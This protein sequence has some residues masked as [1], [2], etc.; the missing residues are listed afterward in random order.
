MVTVYIL[1]SKKADRYY[2]GQTSELENRLRRHN[3]GGSSYTKSGTPWKLVYREKFETRSEAMK[4]EK[5]LKN[6]KNLEYIKRVIHSSRN[7][8]KSE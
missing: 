1:Y 8:L 3:R 7:E 5:K 6:A 2:I 4:R